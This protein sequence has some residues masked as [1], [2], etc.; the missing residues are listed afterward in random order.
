M[1]NINQLPASS[2]AIDIFTS[3]DDVEDG[4]EHAHNSGAETQDFAEQV[5][6]SD[7][8][9]RQQ[10]EAAFAAVCAAMEQARDSGTTYQA[11]IV[12]DDSDISEEDPDS[13]DEP[14]ANV[15]A[16]PKVQSKK[17]E[18]VRK[19]DSYE[20]DDGGSL[21]GDDEVMEETINEA[22]GEDFD[23]KYELEKELEKELE[24]SAA[25]VVD[26]PATVPIL[27]LTTANAS[28][29]EARES[30]KVEQPKLDD[31]LIRVYTVVKE[32]SLAPD[33][34]K[35]TSE[36][37]TETTTKT[38]KQFTSYTEATKYAR[39]QTPTLRRNHPNAVSL[40]EGYEGA[41][42]EVVLRDTSLHTIKIKTNVSIM[43][44]SKLS[45]YDPSKVEDR[46][47]STAYILHITTTTRSENED[48]TKTEKTSVALGSASFFTELAMANHAAAEQF[49]AAIK[50]GPNMNHWQ[51]FVQW[52]AHVKT[53]RDEATAEGRCF[54]GSA[55]VEE[56]GQMSWM[57][58]KGIWGVGVTVQSFGAMGP[59]N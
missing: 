11:P 24:S 13:D 29:S 45:S 20:N 52:Q 16:Q 25:L 40:S 34:S 14:F 35:T 42:W 37:E 50:P 44:S 1:E 41:F 7:E 12:D 26:P 43:S 2:E 28:A 4:A 46:Y 54:T 53:A 31:P 39:Q 18:A 19:L 32:D 8:L 21:F 17:P 27:Q 58:A 3:N 49:L 10:Q 6:T 22:A 56:N 47:P 57:A 59:L 55:E 36:S 23:L 51:E 9:A 38:L 30:E 15:V 48:G 5:P 33:K